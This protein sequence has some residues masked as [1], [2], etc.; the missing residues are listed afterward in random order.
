MAWSSLVSRSIA[1][2]DEIASDDQVFTKHIPSSILRE[3]RFLDDF[4]AQAGA[5]MMFWFFQTRSAFMSQKQLKKWSA[6]DLADYVL[7]PASP[8]FVT[9]RDCF[10]VSH[11]WRSRDMPDPDG[12]FLRLHQ[13]ELASQPWSYIWV[14]WI[15]MPQVPRSAAEQAYFQRCL[16]TMSGII[17]NCGFTYFYP[18]FEPRLWI[19][20]EIAEYVLTCSGGMAVTSDNKVFLQHV[21]ELLESGVQATLAKHSYRCSYVRDRQYLTSW[22]E[23]LVLL[24]R[25]NFDI[26]LV[27]KIMDHLTWLNVSGSRF[28]AEMAVKLNKFEGTLVVNGEKYTFSPFPPWAS[29]STA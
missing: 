25:L 15:C 29:A 1:A 4:L 5:P 16:E 28:Y 27:R 6:N 11:F 8:G 9:R 22:L 18:P 2:W 20:Y 10:F 12:T 7:L 24:K 17:R 23:L 3:C 13:S 14:D 26:D 21:D 19:L